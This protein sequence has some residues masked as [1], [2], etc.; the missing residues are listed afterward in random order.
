MKKTLLIV[1]LLLGV[2]ASASAVSLSDAVYSNTAV[3]TNS[4][5]NVALSD[6]WTSTSDDFTLTFTLSTKALGLFGQENMHT[7]GDTTATILPINTLISVTGT[8]DAKYG[9]AIG[10]AN[11]GAATVHNGIVGMYN[12]DAAT[13]DSLSS[14]S[15]DVKY[16]LSTNASS[17][18]PSNLS[19]ISVAD[20]VSAAVT[21]TC[22]GTTKATAYL[23]LVSADGSST[24]YYGSNTSLKTSAGLGNDLTALGLR[25]DYITSV[26]LMAGI[27]TAEEARLMNAGAIAA[28][29]VPEPAT[30]TLSL[31]A[32]VGLAARRRRK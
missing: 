32:L 11:Y 28:K 17:P 2:A 5:R 15:G 18:T 19:S 22:D 8:N 21:F 12:R 20:I 16:T 30:A 3:T 10:S 7:G 27:A 29:P 24:T 23:T 1:A 31:L 6:V 26:Y 9:L 25:T 14:W 4:S 13:L